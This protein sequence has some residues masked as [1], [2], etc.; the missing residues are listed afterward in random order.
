M[1][2]VKTRAATEK[3]SGVM[4]A[5]GFARAETAVIREIFDAEFAISGY[6]S[7]EALLEAVVYSR[8]TTKPAL[9]ARHVVL[10]KAF[11]PSS[12]VARRA[13]TPGAFANAA[14]GSETWLSFI[15]ALE[16]CAPDQPIVVAADEHEQAAEIEAALRVGADEWVDLHIA[17]SL[18]R[19]RISQVI[20]RFLHKSSVRGEEPW[21]ILASD[22]ERPSP[23]AEGRAPA[24]TP[25]NEHEAWAAPLDE[26]EATAALERV[27]SRS[28]APSAP[29]ELPPQLA[30][31][32]HVPD[33]DLRDAESGRLHAKHI[34]DALGVSLQQLAAVTPLSPQGLRGKPDSP[35]T[36]VALHPIARIV[37]AL[38]RLLPA[39][40]HRAWLQT[41]SMAFDGQTPM[42]FVLSG[43]ASDIARRLEMLEQGG[44][45]L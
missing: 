36:Q 3:R 45:G 13:E 9:R 5:F 43:R 14:G 15:Q 30:A 31:L 34:A 7:R 35:R 1:P 24:P 41:P 44:G 28:Q 21:H 20:E 25:L 12:A 32:L 6:R 29:G 18:L 39:A 33:A 22:N 19:F 23:D 26:G 37:S 8:S 2:G 27:A 17:P 11:T 10:V 42:Q 40:E 16:A 38:R 4:S